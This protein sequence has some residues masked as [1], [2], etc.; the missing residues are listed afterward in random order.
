VHVTEYSAGDAERKY[1]GWSANAYWQV[2]WWM[3]QGVSVTDG[4]TC[5]DGSKHTAP[6]NYAW[7]AATGSGVR[8][9]YEPGLCGGDAYNGSNELTL[10]RIGSA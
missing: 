8:S 1:P 4:I 6:M 3:I 10:T 7:D 9:Y 5:E 2:G